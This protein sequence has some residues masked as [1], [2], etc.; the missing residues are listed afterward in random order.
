[1]ADDMSPAAASTE[2]ET[3]EGAPAEVRNSFKEALAR[4]QAKNSHVENHLDGHSV[5]GHSNDKTSRVF[6]R[7]SGG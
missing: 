4:K 2:A 5:G 7:K 3:T 6:R 1:M